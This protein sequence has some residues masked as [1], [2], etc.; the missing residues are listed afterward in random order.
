M[1]KWRNDEINLRIFFGWILGV[2]HGIVWKFWNVLENLGE[3]A[4]V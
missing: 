2:F 4:P 1:E 3:R